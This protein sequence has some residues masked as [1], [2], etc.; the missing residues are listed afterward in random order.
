MALLYDQIASEGERELDNRG[1]RAFA[2]VTSAEQ[3]M[4]D[5]F[6]DF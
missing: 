6:E 4:D 5:D 3:A 2:E 1:V